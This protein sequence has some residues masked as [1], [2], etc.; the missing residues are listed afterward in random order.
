[1][2]DE[3]AQQLADLQVKRN[4]TLADLDTIQGATRS[5]RRSLDSFLTT[6]DETLSPH[7]NRLD[8][9]LSD[10]ERK[11]LYSALNDSLRDLAKEFGDLIEEWERLQVQE[12][13][14]L[15]MIIEVDRQIDDVSRKMS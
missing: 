5:T 2:S 14:L 11:K 1:M 7:L 9:D 8:N 10:D 13:I 3:L 12:R 4:R 15:Q 6:Q